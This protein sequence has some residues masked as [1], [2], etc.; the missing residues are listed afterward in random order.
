MDTTQSPELNPQVFSPILLD[1]TESTMPEVDSAIAKGAE[2]EGVPTLPELI[3]MGWKYRISHYRRFVPSSQ[4]VVAGTKAGTFH[5]FAAKIANNGGFTAVNLWPPE[6]VND[7]IPRYVGTA[8]CSLLDCYNKK[9][10][11]KKALK[12]AWRQHK[13]W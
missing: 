7:P 9:E 11:V 12:R 2:E 6:F 13:S 1:K 4:E 10:G 5:K 8:R 3:A